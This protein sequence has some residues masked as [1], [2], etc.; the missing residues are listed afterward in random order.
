[1]NQRTYPERV[2]E[3]GLLEAPSSGPSVRHGLQK[4]IGGAIF[5]GV[6]VGT[7]L[8]WILLQPAGQPDSRYLGEILGV[9]A[10]VLYSGALVMATRIQYLE[11]LFGGIDLLY[12]WHRISAT[13]GTALLLPHAL[14]S[15]SVRD[16][17]QSTAGKALGILAF[18][19]LIALVL[20]SLIP[21]LPVIRR[22]LHS[23]Y[24]RWFTL[25]RFIGLF[26]ITALV[27]GILV[28]PVLR[29]S[30]VLWWWYIGIAVLGTCAYLFQEL[31]A[32][33]L[34]PRFDYRVKAV[35]RLNPTTLEV[36]LAP[37]TQPLS[38]VA[39]QFVFVAFGGVACWEY[40]PFTISSTPQDRDLHL[41]IKMLGD[42]TQRLYATLQPGEAAIVGRAFGMFDYRTGGREQIWIAGGI[43]ITPFLSWIRAFPEMLP[44]DIDFYY[45]V[46]TPEDALFRDEI[47]AATRKHPGFRAHLGY[48][49]SQGKLSVE[50]IARTCSGTIVEKDIYMCG[51]TTMTTSFQRRLRKLGLPAH[52]IHFEDFNF[53]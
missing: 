51:P 25:H 13:L 43:G 14:F 29:L 8:L 30:P 5:V 15:L 3:M 2:P 49:N 12:R 52:Q 9:L 50:Y 24:K 37:V 20:W 33:F 48:S 23:N 32:P 44:F 39:G 17:I 11:P 45:T 27:H 4:Y 42:Y 34:R 22:L 10:V 16:P 31:L 1:M 28:D 47:E 6:V 40:H 36:V 35:N 38:F 41:S 21:R 26:V 7:L 53:R 46:R 18:F 19:A